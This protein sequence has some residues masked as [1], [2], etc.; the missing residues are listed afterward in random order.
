MLLNLRQHNQLKKDR[1]VYVSC[2]NL[3]RIF[4][5]SRILEIKLDLKGSCHPNYHLVVEFGIAGLAF[6]EKNHI[7]DPSQFIQGEQ[8]SWCQQHR[9]NVE[10]R[11]L[12]SQGGTCRGE[13]STAL[14]PFGIVISIYVDK[15]ILP[16]YKFGSIQQICKI[17]YALCWI[18]GWSWGGTKMDQTQSQYLGSWGKEGPM[19]PVCH[20]IEREEL[21][22][23]AVIFLKFFLSQP[24]FLPQ[25]MA[26]V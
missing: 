22:G 2:F 9:G 15:V 7:W 5:R 24:L 23:V 26:S 8:T 1:F 11:A 13:V 19:Q 6:K 18:L 3:G 12:W 4:M 25:T 21:L 14:L 10:L 20:G 17:C 16:Y